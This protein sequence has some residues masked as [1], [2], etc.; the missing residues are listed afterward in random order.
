M[1]AKYQKNGRGVGGQRVVRR[2]V[3]LTNKHDLKLRKIA[4]S[5][6]MPK[7]TMMSVMI[8][9]CLENESIIDFLQSQFN[10]M[11]EYKVKPI[12]INGKVEY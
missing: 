2:S 3:S 8:E 11:P 9:T 10:K 6:D 1:T 7:A 4:I 12:R 5:C